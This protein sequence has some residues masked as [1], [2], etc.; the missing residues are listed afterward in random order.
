MEITSV[1][2]ELVKE[3]V[4]LQQKKYRKDK[5]LLEGY[6]AIKE[7]HDSGIE[8]EKIFINKKNKKTPKKPKKQKSKKTFNS[9]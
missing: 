3:T 4:K 5:F 6:K 9:K 2:N 1:N 8:I 7:A